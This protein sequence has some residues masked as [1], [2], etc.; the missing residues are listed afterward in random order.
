VDRLAAALP[1]VMSA[2]EAA[3]VYGEGMDPLDVPEEWYMTPR[4]MA[5][6]ILA[7]LPDGGLDVERLA[8]A[9]RDT[10][11]YLT[12]R[13]VMADPLVR[14]WAKAIAAKV[15]KGTG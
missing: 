9:M 15:K 4:E 8:A 12:E 11:H 7:A 14:D 6:A 2:K 13:R 10:A 1:G 5:A 3:E